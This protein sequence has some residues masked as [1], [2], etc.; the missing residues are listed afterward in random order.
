MIDAKPMPMTKENRIKSR[1]KE[2]S[3][4]RRVITVPWAKGKRVAPYEPYYIVEDGKWLY[5]DEYGDYHPMEEK[6]RHQ[7]GDIVYVPEPHRYQIYPYQ[8]PALQY[9]D[10]GKTFLSPRKAAY[11]KKRVSDKWR[12]AIN[13]PKFA[14]R[15]YYKITKVRVER[16]DEGIWEW[17]YNHE[18]VEV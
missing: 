18:K 4:T 9:R 3:Q 6:A 16:N 15:N 11:M 7:V 14:A 10:D 2:K 17:I 5:M 12:S 13:M 8:V 1:N